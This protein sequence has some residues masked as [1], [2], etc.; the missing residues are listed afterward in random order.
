M[1]EAMALDIIRRVLAGDFDNTQYGTT[2]PVGSRI[3]TSWTY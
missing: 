3:A 2:P 1:T